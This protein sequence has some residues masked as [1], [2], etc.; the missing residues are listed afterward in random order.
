MSRTFHHRKQ[1]AWRR[2]ERLSGK[3]ANARR[4]RIQNAL[5]YIEATEAQASDEATDETQ[6][7]EVA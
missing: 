1:P 6:R 7:S 3:E 2:D 4:R 5:A